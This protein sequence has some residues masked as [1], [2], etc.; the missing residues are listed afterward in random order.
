MAALAPARNVEIWKFIEAS[1]MAIHESARMICVR[2]RVV[3]R[4]RT[5]TGSLWEASTE[6]DGK[7]YSAASRHGAPH[8]LARALVAAG[9][10]DQPVEVRSE[11]CVSDNGAEIR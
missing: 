11:V 5:H 8:A 2:Q 4:S 6:I 7:L 3:P 10:P 9:I 1:G